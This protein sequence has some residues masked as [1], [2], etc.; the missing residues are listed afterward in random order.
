MD[1]ET[2]GEKN[3]QEIRRNPIDIVSGIRK[4]RPAMK[5]QV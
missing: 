3:S 2:C 4:M 5:S 1:M